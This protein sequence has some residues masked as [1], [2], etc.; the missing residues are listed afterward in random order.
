MTAA[1]IIM[2][3]TTTVTVTCAAILWLSTLIEFVTN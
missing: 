3:M 1:T 2:I